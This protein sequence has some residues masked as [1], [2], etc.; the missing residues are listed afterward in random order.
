MAAPTDGIDIFIKWVV[1]LADTARCVPTLI[2]VVSGNYNK[3]QQPPPSHS[4]VD[5]FASQ[6]RYIA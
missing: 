6:T 4:K 1:W 3:K 2:P 5:M